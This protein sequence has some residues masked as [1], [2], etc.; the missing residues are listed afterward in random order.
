ML[1]QDYASEYAARRGEEDRRK[2]E[3]D[4]S[5]DQVQATIAKMKKK[6]VADEIA[7]TLGKIKA[8]EA[9]SRRKYEEEAARKAEKERKEAEIR[10]KIQEELQRIRALEAEQAEKIRIH[11]EKRD[12]Q[13]QL[14][15]QQVSN[16]NNSSR[17]VRASSI[18]IRPTRIKTKYGQIKYCIYSIL[19]SHCNHSCRGRYHLT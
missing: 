11:E 7:E 10:A 15:L 1:C 18:N 2:Q 12:K 14:L 8:Q 16:N 13:R 17:Y 6:S 4:P 19:V 3:E 9:E 5:P